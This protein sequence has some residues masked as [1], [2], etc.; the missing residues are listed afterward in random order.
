MTGPAPSNAGR[1]EGLRKLEVEHEWTRLTFEYGL[2]FAE[3]ADMP[4]WARKLY[5]RALPRIKAEKQL[6]AIEASAFPKLNKEAQRSIIRRLERRATEGR[7]VSQAPKSDA[8][9]LNAADQFGFG[10][11]VVD[12]SGEVIADA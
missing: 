6:T 5:V 1:Y 4:R 9:L 3:I 2:T 7:M 10:V 11:T 8:E 12:K